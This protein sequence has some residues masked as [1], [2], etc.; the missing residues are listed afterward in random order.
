MK[1][2]WL[3]VELITFA[4][5]LPTLTVGLIPL[6]IKLFPFIVTLS[7][8][9]YVVIPGAVTDGE[10]PTVK[11]VNVQAAPQVLYIITL[12]TTV[13]FYVGVSGSGKSYTGV[14]QIIWVVVTDIIEQ[15]QFFVSP[16]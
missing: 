5:T 11:Y 10:F 4:D 8:A 13:T 6:F 1:V 16:T 15:S 9:L 7:P 2:T 14:W 3:L 12:P